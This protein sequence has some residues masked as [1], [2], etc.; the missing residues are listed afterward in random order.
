M[1][2]HLIFILGMVLE[3]CLEF[4]TKILNILHLKNT[5][6]KQN[7]ELKN[8]FKTSYLKKIHNYIKTK[9]SYS[10]IKDFI[11]LGLI[12]LVIYSGLFIKLSI[13]F[14][15]HIKS[16]LLAHLVF[17]GFISLILYIIFL[18]FS[19][20]NAFLVEKKFGF[21]TITIKIFI[22]DN[23]KA[24]ILSLILGGG[25]MA[26]VFAF[27]LKFKNTWWLFAWGAFTLFSLLMIKIYPTFIAP[28]FNKF[29]PVQ[30]KKLKNKIMTMA[31]NA[32][33]SVSRIFKNDTGMGKNKQI[34]LFDTLIEQLS[35]DEITGILAHEIGHYKKHHIWYMFI[36]Q[37]IITG[38]GLFLVKQFTALPVFLQAFNLPE[39]H[40]ITRFIFTLIFINSFLWVLQYPLTL[41][42]RI[43]EFSADKFSF[44]ITGK[45]KFLISSLIKLTK[46]NL[47]NPYPH[48]L[49][50]SLY[51]SHPPLIERV[52]Y[53]KNLK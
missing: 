16:P 26:L 15:A 33:F 10:F 41:L 30:E 49:Y 43:Y 29:V 34:V 46:D 11:S 31:K 48:P 5:S 25:I 36:I 40:Y 32:E 52:K 28:L 9:Y 21:S 20:I 37:T 50:S 53:L 23:I 24:L 35:P 47:A 22:M 13:Y 42:S 6:Q 1:L 3:T 44:Q 12:L 45:S 19:I 51:Y 38:S 17:I 39:V 2:F 18:P 14:T 8:V 4:I 27:I 7:R